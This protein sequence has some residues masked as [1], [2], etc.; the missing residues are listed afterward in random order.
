MRPTTTTGA[1]LQRLAAR[2]ARRRAEAERL[3]LA[4]QERERVGDRAAAQ[5]GL[6]IGDWPGVFELDG[7]DGFGGLSHVG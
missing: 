6:S 1:S 5:A 4:G 3:R 7:F 2:A